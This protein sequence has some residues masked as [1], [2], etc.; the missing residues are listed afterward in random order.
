M[1]HSIPFVLSVATR[2]CQDTAPERCLRVSAVCGLRFSATSAARA[3][4]SH[5]MPQVPDA[6]QVPMPLSLIHI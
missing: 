4:Q 5:G 6:D 3:V 2:H 1:K